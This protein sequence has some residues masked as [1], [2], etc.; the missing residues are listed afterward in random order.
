MEGWWES[1][2]EGKWIDFTH[3]IV[4]QFLM[5]ASS[6]TFSTANFLR[7][8]AKVAF[9]N[10]SGQELIT[11]LP[12]KSTEDLPVEGMEVGMTW[13]SAMTWSVAAE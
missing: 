3:R 9:Q 5:S 2:G 8:F 7:N 11:N 6:N 10:H 1:I 12:V 13:K 4:A